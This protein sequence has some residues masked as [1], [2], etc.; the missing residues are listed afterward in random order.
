MIIACSSAQQLCKRMIWRRTE[1]GK[2]ETIQETGSVTAAGTVF[3]K[4]LRLFIFAFY[5]G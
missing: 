1:S 4:K 5:M 2:G 3:R